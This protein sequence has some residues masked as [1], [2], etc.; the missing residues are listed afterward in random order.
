MDSIILFVLVWLILQAVNR[1]MLS[2][3]V[4]IL[5]GRTTLSTERLPLTKSVASSFIEYLSVFARLV[6]WQRIKSLP[7]KFAR[8]EKDGVLFQT[9]L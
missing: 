3:A 9:G 8:Q 2:S 7:S 5:L 6:I 4:N 1:T